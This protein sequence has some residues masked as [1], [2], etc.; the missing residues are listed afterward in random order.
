MK[1]HKEHMKRYD[2]PQAWNK[3]F[4]ELFLGAEWE[5]GDTFHRWCVVCEEKAVVGRLQ[6]RVEQSEARHL[7]RLLKFPNFMV[8]FARKLKKLNSTTTRKPVYAFSLE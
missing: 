3:R 1:L 5:T 6:Q 7:P 8:A 2:L 4:L